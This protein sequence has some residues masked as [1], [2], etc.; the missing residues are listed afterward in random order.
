[1]PDVLTQNK[2]LILKGQKVAFLHFK[3]GP[4][5]CFKTLGTKHQVK[6]HHIPEKRGCE[7]GNI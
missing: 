6:Q 3:I 2:V 5:R 4:L 1:M 7:T